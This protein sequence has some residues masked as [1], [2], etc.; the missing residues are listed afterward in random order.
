[1]YQCTTIGPV[2]RHYFSRAERAGW[3]EAYAAQLENELAGVRERIQA[4]QSGPQIAGAGGAHAPS[5][6]RPA[7]AA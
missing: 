4:L 5:A 7:D 2:K 6:A 3:L 1:M